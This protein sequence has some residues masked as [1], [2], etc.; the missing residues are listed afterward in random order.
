MPLPASTPVRST[1]GGRGSHVVQCGFA[2]HLIPRGRARPRRRARYSRPLTDYDLPIIRDHS[3]RRGGTVVGG[4]ARGAGRADDPDRCAGVGGAACACRRARPAAAG[5]A[6][7]DSGRCTVM[8]APVRM[9]RSS[10]HARAER[11]V[12]RSSATRTWAHASDWAISVTARRWANAS[13]VRPVTLVSPKCVT[14]QGE[15]RAMSRR[16]D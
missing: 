13:S 3:P 8:P 2:P 6:A 16:R 1:T 10:S 14:S 5:R 4:S 15:H 7:A 11:S 9:L 12:H